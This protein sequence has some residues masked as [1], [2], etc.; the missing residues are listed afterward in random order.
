MTS[1]SI[2]IPGSPSAAL[3]KSAG[4]HWRTKRAA[5]NSALETGLL[6]W[7]EAGHKRELYITWQKVAVTITQFWCGKP[8]DPDNLIGRCGAYLDAAVRTGIIWD[9]GPGCVKALTARYEHVACMAERRI[10][11][12]V[13][14][15]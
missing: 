11:I 1:L 13:E 15:R 14:R 5:W 3:G 12:Q 2:S 6:L 8:L 10:V 7:R 4:G 9:D